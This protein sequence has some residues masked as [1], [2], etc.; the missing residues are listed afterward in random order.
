MSYYKIILDGE[1]IYTENNYYSDERLALAGAIEHFLSNPY[2]SKTSLKLP[3]PE[4]PWLIY[5]NPN[6]ENKLLLTVKN[7]HEIGDVL[8]LLDKDIEHCIRLKQVA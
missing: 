7:K 5:L 8:T 3:T 2:N 1:Q 4:T 6:Q